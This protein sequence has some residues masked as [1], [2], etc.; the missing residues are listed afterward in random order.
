MQT[1][2]SHISNLKYNS[3]I[4]KFYLSEHPLVPITDF[5]L[6]VL[7]SAIHF[8]FVFV[9]ARLLVLHQSY[10]LGLSISEGHVFQK[11]M[12]EPKPRG[13]KNV[14]NW[15][16]VALKST[17]TRKSQPSPLGIGWVLAKSYGDLFYTPKSLPHFLLLAK[18]SS[19]SKAISKI[20]FWQQGY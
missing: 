17:E 12:S 20:L 6:Y 19:D 10:L 4:R 16:R 1:L 14:K 3:V 8:L 2:P 15:F 7:S 13:I 18:F 9:F 11:V 5:L